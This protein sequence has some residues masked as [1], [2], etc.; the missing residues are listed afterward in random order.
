[1]EIR[2]EGEGGPNYHAAAVKKLEHE[3]TA[4]NLTYSQSSLHLSSIN[5][6]I[7]PPSSLRM[8]SLWCFS[9]VDRNILRLKL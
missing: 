4:G 9:D 7:L 2:R 6:R 8:Y 3:I 5:Q 1:M